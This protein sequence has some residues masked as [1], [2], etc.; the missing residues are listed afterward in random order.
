M[1]RPRSSVEA[2]EEIIPTRVII[3]DETDLP[4]ARPVLDVPLALLGGENVIVPLGIDEAMRAVLLRETVSDTSSVLPGTS[5]Q[6]GGRADIERAVWPIG[7]D[8]E[9]SPLHHQSVVDRLL[10]RQRFRGWPRQARN[11][12]RG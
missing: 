5:S 11:G 2:I 8:V 4:P 12:D 6:I 3:E 1:G 9:P 10:A 7:H